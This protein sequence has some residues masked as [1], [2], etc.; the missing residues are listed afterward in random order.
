MM[1]RTIFIICILCLRTCRATIEANVN[2]NWKDMNLRLTRLTEQVLSLK[3]SRISDQRRLNDLQVLNMRLWTKV[4]ELINNKQNTLEE[5]ELISMSPNRPQINARK[6]P[7]TLSRRQAPLPDQD[8]VIIKNLEENQAND[9]LAYMEQSEKQI[10]KALNQTHFIDKKV[11]HFFS[12]MQRR[13][14][15]IDMDIRNATSAMKNAYACEIEQHCEENG[16]TEIMHSKSNDDGTDF[17]SGLSAPTEQEEQ[18]LRAFLPLLLTSASCLCKAFNRMEE[19]KLSQETIEKECTVMRENVHTIQ[20]QLRDHQEQLSSIEQRV[21][22][23]IENM[24]EKLGRAVKELKDHVDTEIWPPL[25]RTINLAQT[26]RKVQ[27]DHF[28]AVQESRQWNNR[29]ETT[30]LRYG[31][32][33]NYLNLQFLNKSLFTAK[34]VHRDMQQDLEIAEI[35][36]TATGFEKKFLETETQIKEAFQK[37]R[38]KADYSQLKEFAV[39]LLKCMDNLSNITTFSASLSKI[40]ERLKRMENQQP[41]DCL[42]E[43]PAKFAAYHSGLYLIKPRRSSTTVLVRCDMEDNGGGWTVIQQRINNATSFYKNWTDY[44]EGFGNLSTNF[45]L[46]NEVIHLLTVQRKYSLRIETIDIF[47]DYRRADYND[48]KIGSEDEKY[49]L[50]VGPHVGGNLTDSFSH[51]RGMPFSTPD[52]DHDASSTHCANFY[53]SGWWFTHCQ[54]VNLN[55]NFHIGMIWFNSDTGDWLQMKQTRMKIRPS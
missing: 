55:G 53:E 33:L 15:Q 18:S 13:L 23:R 51:H 49:S 30:L 24:D 39:D 45:W 31:D 47:G 37:L 12:L 43:T 38:Q 42:Q 22:Y 3:R 52:Q 32:K 7:S 29:F 25:N 54:T 26:I 9:L 5:D 17:G 40:S 50:F 48:F 46:G 20:S 10:E 19:V 11:D 27:M 8:I 16:L 28:N 4:N 2:G 6:E 1:T 14:N 34:E 21:T 35:K 41:I 36:T 44:K